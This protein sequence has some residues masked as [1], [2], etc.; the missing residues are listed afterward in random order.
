MPEENTTQQTET[1]QL[2]EEVEHLRD[3]IRETDSK[4]R[5]V[6]QHFDLWI[7]SQVSM[8]KYTVRKK[9]S[10]N[11]GSCGLSGVNS[12]NSVNH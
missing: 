3:V 1:K 8:R 5:A 9:E 6:L 10:L 12:T 11:Q 2:R 7:D 4:L